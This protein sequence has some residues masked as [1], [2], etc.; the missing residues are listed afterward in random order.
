MIFVF[1]HVCAVNFL[2]ITALKSGGWLLSVQTIFYYYLNSDN[3][4]KM[5]RG[6]IQIP[7][8]ENKQILKLF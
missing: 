8:E 7:L 6:A 3:M 1:H 2:K 5:H 4:I